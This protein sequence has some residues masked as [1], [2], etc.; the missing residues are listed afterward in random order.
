[1][2]D[3][4]L[5]SESA[6]DAPFVLQLYVSRHRETFSQAPMPREQVEMLA[7]HQ[8]NAQISHYAQQFKDAQ[9]LIIE[10]NGERAGRIIV[11]ENSDCLKVID[12]VVAK[13]FQ[14]KGLGSVVFKSF[15]KDA[16]LKK[17]PLRLKVATNNKGGQRFYARL[18]FKEYSRD[19]MNIKLEILPSD[20]VEDRFVE[21]DTISSGSDGNDK[22]GQLTQGIMVEKVGA[23]RD[24]IG[25]GITEEQGKTLAIGV[26]TNLHFEQSEVS[27]G[28]ILPA[29]VK[30]S[31]DVGFERVGEQVFHCHSSKEKPESSGEM[32]PRDKDWNQK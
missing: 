16:R 20:L 11:Q 32:V 29:Q 21:K 2:N 9:F 3:V 19:E 14:G 22:E 17:L 28:T 4:S 5:L 24:D 18:G 31:A 13:E 26:G 1:M 7:K 10:C 8:A 12:V 25:S 30:D 15:I 23:L 27:P 6:E